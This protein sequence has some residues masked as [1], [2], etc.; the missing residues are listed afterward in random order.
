MDNNHDILMDK[1][2]LNLPYSFQVR[3][4]VFHSVDKP[5]RGDSESQYHLACLDDIL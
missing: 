1:P 3:M 5:Y 2:S 4:Y